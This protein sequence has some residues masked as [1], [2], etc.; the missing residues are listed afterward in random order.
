[1]ASRARREEADV[2]QILDESIES[3]LRGRVPLDPGEVAVAFDA[4]DR[5]WAAQV[6]Q[7]TVN[8]FLWDVHR[9]LDA[10]RSGMENATRNG[11][12][13]R[14]R[15]LPRMEVRYV[16]SAWTSSHRDEHQLLGEVM[17]AFLASPTL[18]PPY[19]KG[20]LD[21]VQPFPT[22]KL[23]ATGGRTSSDFWK[24]VDGQLKPMLELLVTLP[25]DV[26]AGAV[27]A[28]PPAEVEV[29]T[30]DRNNRPMRSIRGRI[31]GRIE[32][33]E[34]V[35]RMVRT[36]RGVSMVEEGGHY[37]VPGQP[38]DEVVLELADDQVVVVK[39]EGE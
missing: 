39:P 34:A 24:A 10:A 12:A 6:N 19:L 7:P 14:R 27:L 30:Q 1:L 22:M 29:A 28:E 11:Q 15:P 20:P 18:E 25:V 3:F 2:L 37:L 31:G 5:Q 4:P 23:A 9:D 8:V 17:L 35:G 21:Q 36:R 38:G 16:V 32:D 13:V 26:G 33:P